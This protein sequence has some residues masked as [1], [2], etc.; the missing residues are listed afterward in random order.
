MLLAENIKY[1]RGKEQLNQEAF[2]QLFKIKR[3]ALANYETGVSR[4]DLESL[5]EISKYFDI[6]IDDL[7]HT[8]LKKHSPKTPAKQVGFPLV[9]IEAFAG[10]NNVNFSIEQ[11]DIS[12]YYIVPDFKNVSFMI[13]V[14][15]ESM[16]P[17]YR[18]GDIVA[19]RVITGKNFIQWN[20]AHVIASK[21]QG[22]LIKRIK[23][24]RSE[25]TLTLISDN[26][27]YDESHLPWSDI[28][29]IA[30]VVGVIRLE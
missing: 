1:L 5:V 4:P 10:I 22:I 20:R 23:P 7:L 30:L 6:S 14:S 15:G 3:T 24:G 12:A 28:T 27:S 25:K 26:Q 17:T 13:R 9:D 2:G 18:S 8:D 16:I 21:E 19:C 29:G 11:K